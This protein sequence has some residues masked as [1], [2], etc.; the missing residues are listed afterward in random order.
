MKTFNQPV[1]YSPTATLGKSLTKNKYELAQFRYELGKEELKE[2]YEACVK[3]DVVGIFDSLID[4]L[5][6]LIGTAHTHGMADALMA[7]FEEVHRSNMTKLDKNGL[8]IYDEN[9]K[10]KKSELY[11]KPDLD[12]V[13]RTIYTK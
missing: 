7:G 5:Y 4:Q 10:V 2:Y 1:E 6:V 11:E 13:L 12:K 8:P 9:G 3:D